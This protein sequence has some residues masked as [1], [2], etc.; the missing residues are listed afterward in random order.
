LEKFR[1]LWSRQSSQLIFELRGSEIPYYVTEIPL[2][3]LT[4]PYLSPLYIFTGLSLTQGKCNCAMPLVFKFNSSFLNFFYSELISML[5]TTGTFF[6]G[7]N[8]PHTGAFIYIYIHIY[9]LFYISITHVNPL[10]IQFLYTRI[11]TVNIL[12]NEMK[13]WW[14]TAFLPLSP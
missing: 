8:F 4:F 13:N 1:T 3:N 2:S 10:V 11:N 7:I 6:I 12:Y 5:A 14:A 9:I